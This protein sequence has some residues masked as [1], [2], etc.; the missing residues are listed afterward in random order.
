MRLFAAI[1]IDEEIRIS[2]TTYLERLSTMSPGNKWVSPESLHVT[3]KYI[4]E[5]QKLA[6]I[7]LALKQ[8]QGKPFSLSFRG[9]G[10]FTPRSP[11]VFWAGVAAQPALV[12]LAA[13]IDRSLSTLGVRNEEHEYSPHLTLARTGSGSPKASKADRSKPTMEA[14]KTKVLASPDIQHPDF[15]TM[16]AK[17]FF[18]YQS[19]TSPS[20]PR[21]TKLER[22]DLK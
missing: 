10:F 2:V 8:I 15:G 20:G 9:V 14:L 11:R 18:L 7:T 3:L 12:Q 17:E 19:E 16:H 5:T 22:F 4:G 13:T 1:D 6:E 21:Y